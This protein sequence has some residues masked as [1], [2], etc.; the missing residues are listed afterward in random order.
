MQA[1][2]C[3]R[4]VLEMWL[5]KQKNCYYHALSL[6]VRTKVKKGGKIEKLHLK[7]I[8]VLLST[9]LVR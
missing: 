7:R 3:P 1:F 5:G 6:K 2:V 8:D 9:D 4:R